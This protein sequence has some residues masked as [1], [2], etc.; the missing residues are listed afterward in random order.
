MQN[1]NVPNLKLV[2][3]IKKELGDKEIVN[4]DIQT[5]YDSIES[6]EYTRLISGMF[7]PE[8]GVLGDWTTKE[9]QEIKSMTAAREQEHNS[10]YYVARAICGY[11]D[12]E[13]TKYKK[14]YDT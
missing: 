1:S 5:L 2:E 6:K 10:I 13:V 8:I 9:K 14:A 7:L 3:L 4:V 11:D 12:D